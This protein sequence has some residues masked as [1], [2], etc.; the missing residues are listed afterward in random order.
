MTLRWIPAL[1]LCACDHPDRLAEG[2]YELDPALSDPA[3]W[4]WED[5]QPE[6]SRIEA[7]TFSMG[8]PEDEPGRGADEA[9]HE[10]RIEAPFLLGRTEV[11]Q[12]LYRVVTG[13][14]PAMSVG[15]KASQMVGER[16]P[17][18]GISF[19]DAVRFCNALSAREGLTPAYGIEGATVTWDRAADGFRLPTEAEWE[20]AAR[21]GVEGR[22]AGAATPEAACAAANVADA[23]LQRTDIFPCDDG[24][25]SLTAV[26][27][28]QPNA[29]GL[30][31]MTGNVWEWVWGPAEGPEGL[32]PYRGGSWLDGPDAARVAARREGAPLEISIQ[33]GLRLARNAAEE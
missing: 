5:N 21:A 19:M 14:N 18:Q 13:R 30:Y 31:D 1:L 7:G 8:S 33:L 6:L 10:V 12:G 26:G 23:S 2:N 20:Y 22:Y 29:W 3:A 11:S 25:P 4:T 9:L 15:Y 27:S 16:Y 24:H 28:F 32:R 17:I